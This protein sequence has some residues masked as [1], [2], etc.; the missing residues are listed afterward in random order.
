MET[1]KET[2][3]PKG[4]ALVMCDVDCG[5]QTVGMVKTVLSWRKSNP[6]DSKALWDKL[7]GANEDL[8]KVLQ[9]GD[10][11]VIRE[12]FG[13]IRAL[14]RE[15]G[16]KSGVPIEPQSQTDLLNALGEVEGVV[17]GVVPGAGGFDAV[18]ILVRDEEE[19]MA[20]LNRFLEKWSAEKEG[21]VRLLDVKGEMAGSRIE[22][23]QAYESWIN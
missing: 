2:G 14:I 15:M 22:E 5:S 12:K 16:E 18:V 3:L 20:R 1:R 11:K 19:T 9:D 21:R 17:G 10:E 6:E 13:A 7:H 23:P 4:Y 8:G